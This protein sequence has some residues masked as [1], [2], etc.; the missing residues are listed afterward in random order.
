MLLLEERVEKDTQVE[1][2]WMPHSKASSEDAYKETQDFKKQHRRS[3]LHSAKRTPAAVMEKESK[4]A[5]SITQEEMADSSVRMLSEQ[6]G[7]KAIGRID[8]YIEGTDRTWKH[9]WNEISRNFKME[10]C[11]NMKILIKNSICNI[12]QISQTKQKK[13]TNLLLQRKWI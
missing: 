8:R 5:A 11:S 3:L 6:Q 10:N 9:F 4:G 7:Q 2:L 1:R 12:W 13:P